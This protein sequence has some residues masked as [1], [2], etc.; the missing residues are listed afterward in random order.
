MSPPS[1]PPTSG[2]R[3]LLIEA[4]AGSGKTH[5][6][7]GRILRLLITLRKPDQIIALT[8][9]RKAAGEFFDRI[10]GA[11]A[12]A[13]ASEAGAARAA[14]DYQVAGLTQETALDLLRLATDS[15]HRLSLG[16]LDSFYARV[17]RTFP[18]EFGI[19]G[20]F[21]VIQDTAEAA[22]RREVFDAVLSD[23]DKAD[24]FLGAFRQ[25]TFGALEKRL[26]SNLDDFVTRY[27]RLLLACPDRTAW[28]QPAAI[29]PE[30]P[31]WLAT[32]FDLDDIMAR[33]RDG[34]P[35]VAA[36]HKSAG[37]GFETFTSGLPAFAN[38]AA[39]RT[40]STLHTR[41][42]EALETLH[43]GAA[44]SFDYHKKGGLAL[45]A[46][47][48]QALA[49][50]VGY[51]LQSEIVSKLQQTGGIHDIISRYEAQYHA[52]IRRSGRLSFDDI[53]VL[54]SGA[55]ERGDPAGPPGLSML[56]DLPD[57]GQ[58]RL[59]VD[60][61]LDGRFHHWL[62]DEFQDTSR[63]QWQVLEN[64]IDEVVDDDSGE[65][66][67]Y[68]VG[69]EKQAIYGW[70]GGDS[71]LFQEVKRRYNQPTRPP[72]RQILEEHLDVSWRSGPVILEAV[73]QV[74]GNYEGL[75]ALLGE[76]HAPVIR[77]RWQG[78]NA[79]RHQA[80]PLTADR[81]GYF[82]FVTVEK[83]SDEEPDYAP[84]DEGWQGQEACWR[85]VLE[86]LRD[87]DPVAHRLSVAVLMRRG[88]P[89][90]E[91][92]DFLR[93]HGDIPV[94]LEGQMP[95]G[96]DHPIATS[97]RALLKFAAHP[98]DTAA[99]EHLVMTPALRRLDHPALARER[100][101]LP[102]QILEQLHDRGFGPVFRTWVERLCQALDG[103]LD[104]YSAHRVAQLGEACRRF[105]LEQSRSIG[106]FLAY[107]D[108]YA[109][110]DAPSA[111]VVQIMTVHKAK[112]LTFDAVIV[113]DLKPDAITSLRDVDAVKG[114]DARRQL[115]WL[116]T[117]PRKEIALSVEPLRGAYREAEMD[118]ALEELCNLYVALTRAK[119]ANYIVSPA[120]P[121]N[122]DTST[123]PRN[124]L[125]RQFAAAGSEPREDA[126]G[127]VPVRVR[128]EAGDPHWIAATRAERHR[129]EDDAS[130]AIASQ[131][132]PVTARRRFPTRQ[133]RIPSNA[134]DKKPWGGAARLFTP[135]SG[136]ATG[137]GSVV[138]ALFEQIPWLEELDR[139][140]FA[141]VLAAAPDFAAE[142]LG[143]IDASL[144]LPEIRD[145]F[146]RDRFRHPLLWLEKRFEMITPDGEWISGVFDRV[147]LERDASGAFVAGHIIDFKTNRV[148]TA[149]EIDAATAHYHSQMAVYRTAL[150]RLTDLP[151][152]AIG[153][154][155][156]FTRPGVVRKV[157]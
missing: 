118:S 115:R 41:A 1:H 45:D 66:S 84:D 46:P 120:L 107:L 80:S 134:A 16:T 124:L 153:A 149:T 79:G 2:E 53:L 138:H 142:A 49:D 82:R 140:R 63:R 122:E 11:L 132:P 106:D 152:A 100:S 88:R 28:S 27:H 86:T 14:R 116:I 30:A 111:G 83:S 147:V 126:I 37:N 155:L 47:L 51:I 17:L 150:S 125:A 57:A 24:E 44:E 81:P 4:S 64:L 97:F 96:T 129:G 121:K 38:G 157:F 109:A 35:S 114:Y 101:D 50:A 23:L 92:A 151:A 13:A 144:A 77:Q 128:H 7:V 113:A 67:F 19:G 40:F 156:V 105:D 108:G 25:A 154:E 55:A 148:A 75:E 119:Y 102:R 73:N 76:H 54:L 68:Y 12:S 143:H 137:L 104:A 141:P 93:Q 69:D 9:T 5:H 136:T 112:G 6:L 20:T 94:M 26:L 22:I 98:G 127:G 145:R 52:R 18:G 59:R 32:R 21:E 103:P 62:I 65:R 78:T 39:G 90:A 70:R 146:R 95:I 15:L 34:I 3:N 130:D 56:D 29:W 43:R 133:R 91:L 87:I 85:V 74:F 33:L 72:E 42:M 99:W 61:R 10:L 58:R 89:A 31:W 110:A 123:A 48:Q 71:R 131:R 139:D 8:F 36:Q 60:F 135:D 117:S